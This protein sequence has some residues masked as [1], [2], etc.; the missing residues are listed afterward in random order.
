VAEYTIIK[1]E[2]MFLT[3][4]NMAVKHME[5]WEVAYL[6]GIIDG[7]GSITLTRIHKNEHR[8]PC[9][10]IAS[11]DIE[12]LNYIKSL[13][14]G[15]ISNKKNY[16]PEK[17]KDSFTLNIK[18]KEK[19]IDILVQVLPYLRVPTKRKRALWV[20]EHYD[21]VTIRNGKY[22]KDRLEQKLAFEK[23]FFEIYIY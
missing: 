9:I 4:F 3:P 5:A 1:T 8:R 10:T 6:A 17:H 21:K 15:I 19:V 23:A 11:T 12:L 7:E 13:T 18:K 14:G 2:Q 20:I 16:N 22:S